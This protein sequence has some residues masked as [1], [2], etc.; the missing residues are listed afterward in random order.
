MFRCAK[1]LEIIYTRKKEQY[2]YQKSG[3]YPTKWKTYRTTLASKK[4]VNLF[5]T[6]NEQ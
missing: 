4:A 6:K 1:W 3:N 2:I 5:A